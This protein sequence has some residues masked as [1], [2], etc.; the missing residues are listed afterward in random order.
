MKPV[1]FIKTIACLMLIIVLSC[2]VSRDLNRSFSFIQITDPQFGFI[3]SNKGI[4]EESILY[5]KA[6][7]KIN[8]MQPAF[9]VITGDLVNDRSDKSQWDEFRRITGLIKPEIKVYFLPGNHDIGQNPEAADLEL[10]KSMFGYERFS[11]S[12]KKVRFIGFNSS[13][14]KAETPVLMDEQYNWLEKELAGNRGVKLTILFCHYPFF[15]KDPAEPE[16]YSNIRPDTR[17]KYLD[18]FSQ[19]GVDALFSGH[20]HYNASGKY[21]ETDFITTSSVGKQ[22][23]KDLPGF[24]IIHVEGNKIRHEYIPLN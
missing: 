12:L 10:Y 17:R 5:E 24:R 13:L 2:T 20:L 7:E 15:I 22:L 1:S 6:V 19:Y 14:I 18:L 16:N 21:A 11:F 23:G 9:V 3:S 4:S 8:S